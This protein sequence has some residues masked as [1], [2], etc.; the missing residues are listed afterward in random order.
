M[1]HQ[2]M[3][4]D[5]WQRF[6][7]VCILTTLMMGR[8]R[9]VVETRGHIQSISPQAT[10]SARPFLGMTTGRR[11]YEGNKFSLLKARNG[12]EVENVQTLREL[13]LQ[14]R[15]R[16][17]QL[18]T[19]LNQLRGPFN[20]T[21]SLLSSARNDVRCSKLR[22]ERALA[23]V[24]ELRLQLAIKDKQVQDAEYTKIFDE[25][26]EDEL[27]VEKLRRQQEAAQNRAEEAL[28]RVE[29]LEVQISEL[30]K[31][32]QVMVPG[33][34]LEKANA[35][36]DKERKDSAVAKQRASAALSQVAELRAQLATAEAREITM[37]SRS[38]WEA[39]I[40]A[41]AAERQ[42]LERSKLCAADALTKVDDLEAKLARFEEMATEVS[43]SNELDQTEKLLEK[44]FEES[45]SWQAEAK[46]ALAKVER[47]Q[48]K[49]YDY[50]DRAISVRKSLKDLAEFVGVGGIGGFFNVLLDDENIVNQ[51]KDRVQEMKDK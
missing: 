18:Q 21:L 24:E 33:S 26:D 13:L 4:T 6:I 8:H 3:R 20:Q 19:A 10:F 31:Q 34:E 45:S 49:L 9:S 16:C 25:A 22:E 46:D 29:H 7:L 23:I 38:E 37:V 48:Q 51:I 12:N 47:M 1:K 42:Q 27:E 35:L 50:Q 40:V 39:V 2:C 44:A 43:D 30:K 28:D 36:L 5:G 15:E 17:D 11:S 41:L 32:A 14:E